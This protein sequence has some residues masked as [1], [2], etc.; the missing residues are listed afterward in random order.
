MDCGGRS[1]LYDTP[2]VWRSL[3][4][5][6]TVDSVTDGLHGDEHAPSATVFPFLAPPDPH[7]IDH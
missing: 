5:D 4:V 2:N 3:L 6:G 7:G 1:P